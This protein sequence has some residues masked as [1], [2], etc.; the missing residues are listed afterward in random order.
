[1]VQILLLLKKCDVFN[2]V[3]QVEFNIVTQVEDDYD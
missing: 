1:M 2:I 3:A